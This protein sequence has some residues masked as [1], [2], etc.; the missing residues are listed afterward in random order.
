MDNGG[1]VHDSK[2]NS[3]SKRALPLALLA[4]VLALASLTGS[5]SA[6]K[7]PAKKPV[8]I[9]FSGSYSGQATTKVDGDTATIVANGNGKSTLLGAGAIGGQGTAD[10]SQQPCIPFAGTGTLKGAGGTLTFKMVSGSSGCGDEGGHI[11]TI[12]AHFA[13]LKATGKLAK[14]KGTLKMTGVYSHDD[15]SF[16]VKLSGKLLK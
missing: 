10:T 16:T 1:N 7:P 2:E 14:A 9:V 4:A 15:G 3:M 5:A 8:V 6:A 12:S 11:F 13:A